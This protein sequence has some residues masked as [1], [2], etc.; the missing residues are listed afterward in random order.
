MMKKDFLH[1]MIFA[2]FFLSSTAWANDYIE[3]TYSQKAGHK[4]VTEKKCLSCSTGK[5]NPAN[6][7]D[8]VISGKVLA[9]AAYNEDGLACL[10]SASGIFCFN[11]RGLARKVLTF[12]NGPDYFQ[13]GLART[14]QKGKIGFIDKKLSIVV[15]P[16]YDF[17]FP[18][19]N[20]V[21]VVCNGCTKKK[22]GEHT[23]VAGGRWGAIDTRGKIIQPVVHSKSELMNRLKQ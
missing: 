8:A 14:E 7:G 1:L 21:S 11:E 13:E 17:A 18:F 19:S 22:A 9:D 6:K 15:R 4:T 10:Y 3:C 23:E 2:I 16:E 20:G 12:D 5:D